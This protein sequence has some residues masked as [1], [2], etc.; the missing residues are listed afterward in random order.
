MT[1]SKYIKNNNDKEVK[2]KSRDLVVRY[3]TGL[4]WKKTH[5]RKFDL[6][7]PRQARP[8]ILRWY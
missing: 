1:R 2:S 8:E 7:K 5:Q 6:P 3:G 4:Q